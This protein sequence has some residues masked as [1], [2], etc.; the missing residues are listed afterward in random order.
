MHHYLPLRSFISLTRCCTGLSF[1]VQ[2]T[3]IEASIITQFHN[4]AYIFEKMVFF[5]CLAIIR[6]LSRCHVVGVDAG[7][8]LKSF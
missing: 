2:L 5:F 7:K 1:F 3:F 8:Q 6:K 4:Q